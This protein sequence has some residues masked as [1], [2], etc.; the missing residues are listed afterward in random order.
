MIRRATEADVLVLQ[1]LEHMLDKTIADNAPDW[2]QPLERQPSYFAHLLTDRDVGMFVAEVDGEVV[3]MCRFRVVP[4]NPDPRLVP[5]KRAIGEALVVAPEHRRTDIGRQ[6]GRAA[7]DW[8]KSRGAKSVVFDIWDNE[9][10]RRFY[11][12][13]FTCRTAC[14]VMEIEV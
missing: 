5:V 7:L 2:F 3:G 10:A 8:A 9:S 12:A 4:V 1:K 13:T 6:L 11:E 14:S